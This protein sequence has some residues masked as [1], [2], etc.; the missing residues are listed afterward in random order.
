MII[1]SYRLILTR[2][3]IGL[4]CRRK[5]KLKM[6]MHK[7]R[8]KILMNSRAAHWL[9]FDTMFAEV[10]LSPDQ[11]WYLERVDDKVWVYLRHKGVRIK[12]TISALRLYFEEVKEN[13]QRKAD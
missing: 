1:I 5:N 12:L 6:K 4:M 8:P 7:Y 10:A 9:G 11:I 13:E 2:I 3:T